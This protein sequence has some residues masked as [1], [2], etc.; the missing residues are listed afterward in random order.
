MKCRNAPHGNEDKQIGELRTD[1][2][3]CSPLAFRIFLTVCSLFGFFISKVDFESAFLQTG[4]AQQVVYVRPPH[5][6]PAKCT[7]WKL[8]VAAYGLVNSNAK[9]KC[10]SDSMLFNC[11]LTQHVLIPQ[12]FYH[13][14]NEKLAIIVVK[15]VDDL[16][17][18][19]A[20]TTRAALIEKCLRGLS[21]V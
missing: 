12:L 15:L 14:K 19:G 7:L 4:P 11:G 13:V 5:S 16:L 2:A 17:I 20:V 3:T 9:W 21:P 18:G 10:L 6:D 8:K 1:S